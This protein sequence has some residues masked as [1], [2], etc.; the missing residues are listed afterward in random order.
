[1]VDYHN[2]ALGLQRSLYGDRF[3]GFF[4]LL[5]G[6]KDLLTKGTG[7]VRTQA[8]LTLQRLCYASMVYGGRMTNLILPAYEAPRE[9]RVPMEN[10]VF[11][12]SYDWRKFR[13]KGAQLNGVGIASSL[14]VVAADTPFNEEV[15]IMGRVINTPY[16]P[17]PGLWEEVGQFV[18]ALKFDGKPIIP[19]H[20]VRPASFE[21]WNS[22]FPKN[23]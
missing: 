6:A 4:G 10:A 5:F 12:F 23:R 14:P 13:T 11:R 9:T 17:E 2:K 22:R 7:V 1:M 19:K 8:L 3:S 15:A 20:I 18:R 21:I 16:H